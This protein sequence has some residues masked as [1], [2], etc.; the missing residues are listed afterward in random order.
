MPKESG[1]G[2]DR[3][4]NLYGP[5]LIV[6]DIAASLRFYRDTIGLKGETDG[7]WA[8][9][10]AGKGNHLVLL[11]S[12]FWART[13]RLR[14]ERG[15]AE[16]SGSPVIAIQVPDVA[17]LHRRLTAAGFR[18]ELAPTEVPQMGNQIAIIRD[19]DGHLVELS[20]P[21]TKEDLERLKAKH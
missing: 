13:S 15:S 8:E 16:Q 14:S 2:K 18:S 3:S 11:D 20:M 6:H 17:D 9:F 12:S 21:L 7:P 5:M 10:S 1:E 19:P 4:S